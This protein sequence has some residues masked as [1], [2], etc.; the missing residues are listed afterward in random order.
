MHV[1]VCMYARMYV[2]MDVGRCVRVRMCSTEAT[3]TST[4]NVDT[5][6]LRHMALVSKH[7][8]LDMCM[9]MRM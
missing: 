5:M 7:V 9:H 4:C 2:R 1:H 6:H 3:T 8:H